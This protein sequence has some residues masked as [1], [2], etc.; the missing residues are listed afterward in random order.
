[1]T[2]SAL[3]RRAWVRQIMGMPI[4]IHLRGTATTAVRAAAVAAVYSELREVDRVFSTYRPDSDISRLRRGEISV[5]D[6]DPAVDEVL[7]LCERARNATDGYFDVY[8]AGALDPSGYVKG[9]AV[10]VASDRLVASGSTNHCLN[11][12]GDLVVRGGPRP[13]E[14]WRIGIRHP[15]Q[16]QAVC[17]VLAVSDIAVATSGTYERGLHVIDPHTGRP[18]EDLCSV[19]VVG[20]DL[21]T[22]DAY[23]TAAVAMGLKGL[24]WLARLA[25]HESAAVTQ[26]ARASRSDHLP[27]AQ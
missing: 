27:L 15:F 19:T 10:Q 2:A 18:A 5:A 17:W 11:A 7:R 25:D 24:D 22:A 14:P 9:W 3:G 1:M 26:D 4:S 23:A 20:P 16:P 12:A 21:G 6:G 13:G 8:A